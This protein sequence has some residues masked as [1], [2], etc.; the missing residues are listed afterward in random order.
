MGSI[1]GNSYFRLRPLALRIL[2]GRGGLQGSRLSRLCR[3]GC[4]A[5]SNGGERWL[6]CSSDQYNDNWQTPTPRPRPK[7]TRPKPNQKP[8]PRSKSKSKPRPKIKTEAKDKDQQQYQ[9]QDE[10]EKR[11]RESFFESQKNFILCLLFSFEKKKPTFP[12]LLLITW[13]LT[14][15]E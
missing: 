1:G 5:W 3:T 14:Q 10:E 15:W 11:K 9:Y 2:L 13:F 6:W 8:K 7:P 4:D 12:S